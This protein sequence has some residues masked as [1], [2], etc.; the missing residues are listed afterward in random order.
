VHVGVVL[1]QSK[2]EWQDVLDDARFAE[3]LGA[4]SVWVVDHVLSLRPE[5]GILE[6]WTL[7]SALAAST[8]RVEIGA[9]V[10]CQ[11]FRDPALLAKMAA[12]LDRVS[13]GRLRLLVGAG[14]F[15]QEYEAFGWEFPSPGVL[16]EQLR[17][18]IAILKGLLS[19]KPEPFTFEGTHYRVNGAVN[20]P[21]PARAP[22]PIE[23][24]GARDRVLRTVARDADG[25]N[26]PS[27]ALPLLDDRIAFLTEQCERYGRSIKELRLTCQIV[28]AVGDDELTQKP[29][30]A[31]FGPDHG[32]VGSVDQAVQ[33]AGEMIEK[34][35]EGFHVIVARGERGRACLERLVNEVRPQ[36]V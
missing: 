21:Q 35:I 2:A 13:G 33:R 30:L 27:I 19:G 18:T 34:G 7:M 17:E 23:V 12:T 26:C 36:L 32:L 14:W 16:V 11:S 10:L 1:P 24:G 4:D 22:M 31:M 5:A 25:W 8:E 20:A 9:Q 6:A 28:C 3:S 15:Q 29:E